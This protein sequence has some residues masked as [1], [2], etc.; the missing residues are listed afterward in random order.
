MLIGPQDLLKPRRELLGGNARKLPK[1]ADRL[2]KS[3]LRLP[4]DGEDLLQKRGM[5]RFELE[6]PV[7]LAL[8]LQLQKGLFEGLD[9][10]GFQLNET[11]ARQG[12]IA[13][14]LAH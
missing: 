10:V 11:L 8:G 12:K 1:R 14:P 3:F 6:G 9:F 5:K 13:L 2:L 7:A 4:V